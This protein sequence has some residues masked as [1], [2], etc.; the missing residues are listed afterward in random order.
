MKNLTAYYSKPNQKWLVFFGRT[1]TEIQG[2]YSWELLEDLTDDLRRAGL[3]L[4]TP[5]FIITAN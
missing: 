4:N 2:V 3:K 5:S 1:R